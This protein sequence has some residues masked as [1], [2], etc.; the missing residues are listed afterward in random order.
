MV[1][2]ILN[3]VNIQYINQMTSFDDFASVR[4]KKCCKWLK[5]V[6]GFCQ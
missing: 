3:T 2:I 6:T 5:V 1:F 4:P